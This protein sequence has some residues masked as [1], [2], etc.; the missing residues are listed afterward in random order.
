ME[1]GRQS[2]RK[3]PD[4]QVLRAWWL[5]AGLPPP[6]PPPRRLA[7]QQMCPRPEGT[8]LEGAPRLGKGLLGGAGARAVGHWNRM[9]TPAG[10]PRPP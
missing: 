2:R 6:L 3:G 7:P 1:G 10:Q 8:W 9:L 4:A 5:V